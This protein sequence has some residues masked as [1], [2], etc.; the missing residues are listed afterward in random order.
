VA[1]VTA[2]T[3]ISVQADPA[4]IGVNTAGSTSQQATLRA[5]VRDGTPQN[6]LVKNAT[7]AFSI[8][9]D[10]SGGS[11][12]QP[13]VVTTGADGVATTSF[14]AGTSATAKD[15][16]QSRPW[17]A[18]GPT[19]MARLTVAQK[20]L[21][22]SAGTG[23]TVGVPSTATYQMDAVIVTD[24]AGNAVSGVK[25][26]ASVLPV[27][28]YGLPGTLAVRPVGAG[29]AYPCSNEDVNGNGIRCGRGYQR[30]RRARSGHSGHRHAERDH[31]RHRPRHGVAD[32]PARPG[33]L[34][35]CE[36]DDTRPG[37]RH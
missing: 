12:T 32:L 36:P 16:V 11:L 37:Q 1:P 31:R 15:G 22:I 23:N 35:R 17:S 21:F 8:L 24:A 14:I 3:T 25:L 4:V 7:V 18:A 6:N 28:Y 26:T 2:L 9:S 34:A 29:G 27:Q 19:A 33:L 10:P 30:Q 5:I 13:A 20:S